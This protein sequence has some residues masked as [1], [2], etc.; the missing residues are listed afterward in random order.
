[1]PAHARFQILHSDSLGLDVRVRFVDK[2]RDLAI[3]LRSSTEDL[4]IRSPAEQGA[5][6]VLTLISGRTHQ[7][8]CPRSASKEA[9]QTV[10][11]T[12]SDTLL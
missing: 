6:W 10:K 5:V 2:Q 8:L 1:M 3:V 12:N 9:L 11:R 4:R 7:H